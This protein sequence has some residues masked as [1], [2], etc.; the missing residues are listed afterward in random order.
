MKNTVWTYWENPKGVTRE[1]AYITLCRWT[2]LHNLRSSTL[3]AVTP[4]NLDKY[5]PGMTARLAGVQAHAR[6]RI[7]SLR[8]L[9]KGDTRSLAIKCDVIRAHLLKLY[10][11]FYIDSD[12]IILGDLCHYFRLL[13]KHE[14][15]IV[16]RASHGKSHVSVNFYGSRPFGKVINHY[17]SSQTAAVAKDKVFDFTALGDVTLN[18]ITHEYEG[19]ICNIP[20]REIQAVTY[21]ESDTLLLSTTL[22]PEDVLKGH[23]SVFM[24]FKG[25]FQNQLKNST[26]EELYYSNILLSKIYRKA[27][28]QEKFEEFLRSTF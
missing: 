13:E 12:A 7:D 16:K 19:E 4:E 27:L 17:T 9:F 26:I 2:M 8:R 3:V 11:G 22:Q 24:L 6:G 1:P 23:E 18:P 25:I 10:G 28:P 14:F 15:A 21:E 5:L 20:E